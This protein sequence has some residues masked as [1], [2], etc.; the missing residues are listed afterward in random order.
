MPGRRVTVLALAALVAAPLAF[1][2]DEARDDAGLEEVLVAGEQPG[3][4]LW[5]V[6]KGDHVLWILGTVA[7]SPAKMQWRSKQVEQVVAG[8][9]EVL[10]QPSVK[11][12]I[13][14]FTALRLLP[15][16]MKLRRNPHGER[17][18]DLLAPA[19][20][21]RWRALEKRFYGAKDA[22]DEKGGM[23]EWRPA[24]VATE[25]W[26]QA[27]KKSGLA[28]GS[29]VWPT[30]RQLAREHE[31]PVNARE[32]L[33]KVEKPRELIDE[34]R[35]S[36]PANEVPCFEA[37]IARIENDLDNMRTRATAWATGDIETLRRLRYESQTATCIEAVL[38]GRRL[39]A[40]VDQVRRQVNDQW[41]NAAG[42]A[43]LR[44]RVTF[45]VLPMQEL[46]ATDGRLESL[47]AAGYTIEAPESR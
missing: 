20:Y 21:E 10:G 39:R 22:A 37:T 23:E 3:P 26:E 32:F 12:D 46:L 47:R 11:P 31:V 5:K 6:S 36:P 44:N 4:A 40:L 29:P 33:E 25:L 27:L 15:A 1:S 41:L 17:L 9:D 16:L 38:T 28:Q 42:Y 45:A 19:L 7:P 35:N 34:L 24:F 14:M 8:A 13:G 18:H 30:V 2:M 43:L